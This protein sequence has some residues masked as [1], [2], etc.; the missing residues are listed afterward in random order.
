MKTV[1]VID[2]DPGIVFMH[3]AILKSGGYQP[4]TCGLNKQE[5]ETFVQAV[6]FVVSDH[7]MP[8]INSTVVKEICEKFNKPLLVV[9]GT[10]DK[11]H[12]NQLS[13]P[14]GRSEFLNA[15]EALVSSI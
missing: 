9:S 14:C 7:D 15:V 2:D 13:K 10:L 11:V 4:V 1:L 8:P 6:D 3:T 5:I 12:T